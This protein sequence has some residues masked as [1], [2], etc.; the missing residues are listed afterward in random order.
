MGGPLTYS[1]QNTYFT[2]KL[3]TLEAKFVVDAF[4]LLNYYVS[5][6]KAIVLKKKQVKG[7]GDACNAT[8]AK[9]DSRTPSTM[10]FGNRSLIYV[11]CICFRI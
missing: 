11:Y 7:T 5:F 3:L 9:R 10:E 2:L 1:F 6:Q 4:L 8:G